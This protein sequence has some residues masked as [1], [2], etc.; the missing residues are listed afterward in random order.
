MIIREVWN[1]LVGG[2]IT[3]NERSHQRF[4]NRRALWEKRAYLWW[5]YPVIGLYTF[6]H[7]AS[8]YPVVKYQSYLEEE[9]GSLPERNSGI[10]AIQA[11][12]AGAFWPAYWT[13]EFMDDGTTTR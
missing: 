5:L 2:P 12:V 6:G 4:Y 3:G 9:S 10:T 13:W 8:N 7:C 1:W 11:G